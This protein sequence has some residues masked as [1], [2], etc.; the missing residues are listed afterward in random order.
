M[1]W[2][3]KVC[4]SYY[5][6]VQPHESREMLEQYSVVTVKGGN[7][8]MKVTVEFMENVTPTAEPFWSLDDTG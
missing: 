3:G 8:K 2:E 4:R 6:Y 5:F 1:S 7:K